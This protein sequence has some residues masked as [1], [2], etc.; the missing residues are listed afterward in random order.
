MLTFVQCPACAKRLQVPETLQDRPVRC[1]HCREI[2]QV[3]PEPVPSQA[4][5][6]ADHGITEAEVIS[7]IMLDPMPKQDFITAEEVAGTIEF[8]LSPAARNITG[9]TIA[10]DG[11][12]TAR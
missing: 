8:L 10:I 7:R 6:A 5:P 2:F 3:A 4:P 11:G 9:Q 1:P 12:W